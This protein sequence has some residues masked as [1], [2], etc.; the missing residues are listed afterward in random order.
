MLKLFASSIFEW[1]HFIGATELNDLL[2]VVLEERVYLCIF[3]VL[4]FRNAFVI[5][6][7][8]VSERFSSM[9]FNY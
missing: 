9:E 2:K 7:C 1:S 8:S 3:S 6:C 4:L 5:T